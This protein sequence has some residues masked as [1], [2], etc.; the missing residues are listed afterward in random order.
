MSKIGITGSTGILGRLFTKKLDSQNLNYSCFEGDIQSIDD[1]RNWIARNEF[2]FIIHLAAIVP[3]TQVK[4]NPSLAYSVNVGGTK[5]LIDVLN[6]TGEHPWLFYSSTSHVYASSNKPIS[7]NDAKNPI[8]EYGKTKYD[9]EKI[10]CHNYENH[11][12]GR[13]FSFYH[14]TQKKPFLYPTIKERLKK[15]DLSKV[16][17]LYGADSVRDFL[18]A[19]EVSEIIFKLMQKKVKG[20]YN[21][22]SGK[23]IRIEDFVR[24]LTKKNIKINKLGSKDYLV[25][26]VRNLNKVLGT[27]K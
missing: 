26:D 18:N 5:N 2:D 14:D 15:E 19:E 21:I 20:I 23:G 25:A 6:E 13:I 9:A 10:I 1:V 17:S 22:A 24:G 8:S 16:F 7:E 12:I 4:E 11:C 3:T 27:D